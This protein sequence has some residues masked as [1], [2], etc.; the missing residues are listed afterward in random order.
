MRTEKLTLKSSEKLGFLSNLSTMITAGIP[1]LET[2]D[3]LL[4]DS[5]GNTKKVLEIIR[6]DIVQGQHLY[7]SFAKFPNIFDK[8]TINVIRA[9]EEAGTLDVTLK[10]LKIQIQKE[11]QF[12][13]KIKG[14]LTYPVIILAVFLAV[15]LLI[16]TVVIPKISTVFSRLK[17]DLPLATKILITVSNALMQHTIPVVIGIVLLVIGTIFL[18]RAQRRRILAIIYK[19]PV[20]SDLVREIDLARFSRS[21]FLLLTS[22]ITITSALELAQEIVMRKDVSNAIK[23]AKE[24]VL[25][26]KNLSQGFKDQRKV[27]SALIIK[28]IEAGEKTGT[29]DKSMQ[30]ISEQQDYRVDNSLKTLTTLLEPVMLVTV[31]LL[32]GGVMMAIIAPI[33]GLIGQVSAR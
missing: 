29:L 22:G 4:E 13:D 18:Y 21:M 8:V 2:I 17:A 25:G 1:I 23:Y 12:N 7:S 9:S 32:V 24:T 33:Y 10:D 27:F 16:L 14:A 11:M 19:A 26:G 3:S 30:D 31:G 15:L 6:E 20:I 28:I 5:K